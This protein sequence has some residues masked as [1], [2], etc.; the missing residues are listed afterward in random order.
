MFSSLSCLLIVFDSHRLNSSI[1]KPQLSNLFLFLLTFVNLKL[2][3]FGIIHMLLVLELFLR[4]NFR[5]L[6]EFTT[7]WLKRENPAN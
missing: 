3:V 4:G 7:L 6:N 2:N 1:A 5:D